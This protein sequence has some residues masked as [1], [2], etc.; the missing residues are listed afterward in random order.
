MAKGSR[1]RGQKD[2][3]AGP[4]GTPGSLLELAFARYQAGDMVE[5]RRLAKR[6]LAAPATAADE[7]AA[8]NLAVELIAPPE[9]TA[10]KP[11]PPAP[12]T[13]TAHELAK[14]LIDRTRVPAKA[15]LFAA[16]SIALFLGL[17]ALALTRA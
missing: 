6:L 3:A 14:L 16:V 8:K 5:A 2:A 9:Q 17:L 11:T 15:Y 4:K 1:K 12:A 7:A 13:P 10:E